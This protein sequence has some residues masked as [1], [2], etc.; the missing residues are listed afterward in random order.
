MWYAFV[1]SI[2]SFN[3]G[4][5]SVGTIQTWTNLMQDR[6]NSL[7]WGRPSLALGERREEK[8][9]RFESQVHRLGFLVAALK[10]GPRGDTGN[11]GAE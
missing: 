8:R 6:A 10:R 5:L 7:E 3:K 9:R 11:F 1:K 2:Y 4:L